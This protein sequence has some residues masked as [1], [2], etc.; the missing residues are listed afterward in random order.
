[1]TVWLAACGADCSTVNINQVNWFKIWEG[2][3]LSGNQETGN[4]YQKQFQRF[5]GSP[6]LWPV[7]IPRTL[8]RGLYLVR[9]EIISTHVAY[10]PQF[11]V[12]CAHLNITGTGFS[13][14]SSQYMKKFPGAY[15]ATGMLK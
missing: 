12:E 13:F 4:W 2:G 7:T 6:G 3:L 5:D 14:P 9:H 8:R 15:V 10:K 11:Y 1:M